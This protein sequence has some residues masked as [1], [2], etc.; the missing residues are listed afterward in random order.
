MSCKIIVR[1]VPRNI[2]PMELKEIFSKF[3]EILNFDWPTYPNNPQK[4]TKYLF[5]TFKNSENA[6]KACEEMNEKLLKNVKIFVNFAREKEQ[7]IENVTEESLKKEKMLQ[8]SILKN[9]QLPKKEIVN[10]RKNTIFVRNLKNVSEEQVKEAFLEC[11]EIENI[12]MPIWRDTGI[13]QI[14]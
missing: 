10:E 14:W 4:K 13:I 8:E 2:S 12:S 9:L 5:L 6:K 1:N 11:G 7:P 3:G